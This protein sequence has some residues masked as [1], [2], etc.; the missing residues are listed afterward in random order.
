LGGFLYNVIVWFITGGVKTHY[1]EVEL[2]SP[3]N[4]KCTFCPQST[5]G[6]KRSQSVMTKGQILTL[7]TQLD[8]L[9]QNSKISI[10]FCGMGENL[11]R[12]D[13]ILFFIESIKNIDKYSFTLVTNGHLLTKEFIT[14]P[15]VENL[16][17]EISMSGWDSYESIYKLSHKKVQEKIIETAKLIGP[18]LKIHWVRDHNLIEESEEK[19]FMEWY[20]KNIKKYKTKYK[21]GSLHTRGGV[22]LYPGWDKDGTRKFKNCKIFSDMNFISSDGDMLSCCHDVE[23]KNIIDNIDKNNI[24]DMMEKKKL[25]QKTCGGFD[26]CNKCTD[27]TLEKQF[28]I[29]YTNE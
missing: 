25:M 18:R 15:L 20:Y 23:S 26:I 28:K 4:A 8:K 14:N 16:K 7:V 22:Y 9:S 1:F 17:I 3:C 5:G 24:T 13:L 6:V 29:T 2:C 21:F 12:K 11:I 27:F 10:Y 19:K